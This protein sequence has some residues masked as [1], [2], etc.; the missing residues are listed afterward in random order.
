MTQ[1][2]ARQQRIMDDSFIIGKNKPKPF[3]TF[4]VVYMID[5]K[6]SISTQPYFTDSM[7]QECFNYFEWV[8]FSRMDLI[9]WIYADDYAY[10]TAIDESGI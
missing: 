4:F 6:P 10:I 7:Q 5:G 1:L 2:N 3:A 9:R 8:D